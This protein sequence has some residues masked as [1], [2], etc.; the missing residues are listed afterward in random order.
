MVA[1]G[2]PRDPLYRLC[3]HAGLTPI[4]RVPRATRDVVAYRAISVFLAHAM[5]GRVG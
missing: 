2:D 5:F 4:A 3:V 1:T